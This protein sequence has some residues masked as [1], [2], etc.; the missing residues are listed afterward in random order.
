MLEVVHK[1]FQ[2]NTTFQG[3][4]FNFFAPCHSHPETTQ[5][6]SKFLGHFPTTLPQYFLARPL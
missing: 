5:T 1:A 6:A 3:S 4:R 2:L